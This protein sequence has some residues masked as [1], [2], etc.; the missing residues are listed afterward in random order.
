MTN[1]DY[2]L[3]L[4]PGQCRFFELIEKLQITHLL[5]MKS[6]SYISEA[7]DQYLGTASHGQAIM[8]RFCLGVWT[9]NNE[10]KFDFID[11]ALTLDRGNK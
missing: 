2:K 6:R 1:V 7:V 5:D 11:A 10:F 9:H 3:S 8:L 4:S